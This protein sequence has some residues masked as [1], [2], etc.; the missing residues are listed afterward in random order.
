M[1]FTI[2]D[3]GHGRAGPE[4]GGLSETLATAYRAISSGW[5]MQRPS[6]ISCDFSQACC[7]LIATSSD[8]DDSTTLERCGHTQESLA[9]TADTLRPALLSNAR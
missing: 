4:R 8:A 6:K 2:V 9:T 1:R 5:A 3:T 7:A